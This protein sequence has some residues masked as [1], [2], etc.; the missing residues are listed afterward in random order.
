MH[1]LYRC[2]VL[3]SY[4]LYAGLASG[5]LAVYDE[6]LIPV[7]PFAHTMVYSYSLLINILK[8]SLYMTMPLYE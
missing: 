7:S 3:G 5:Q 8:V 6:Y 4:S 2:S 1:V